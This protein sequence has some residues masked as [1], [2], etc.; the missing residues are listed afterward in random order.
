MNEDDGDVPLAKCRCVVGREVAS[1]QEDR[2]SI[3]VEQTK[4][5]LI[6]LLFAS[7]TK[8]SPQLL[9]LPPFRQKKKKKKLFP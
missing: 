3:D 5:K 9:S 6:L 8:I 7:E 2:N 4:K 1:T